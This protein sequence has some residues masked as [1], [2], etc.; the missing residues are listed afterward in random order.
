M[1]FTTNPE[2]PRLGWG[3]DET[4]TEQNE[5]YLILS[6]EE[7]AKGFI[8]PVRMAYVHIGKPRPKYPLRDL[9]DAE[10]EH[11]EGQG[12]VKFEEYPESERPKLGKYWTQAQLDS[13]ENGCGTLTIM[14]REF[15][16]TYARNPQFYGS[17]YCVGCKKH[18]PVSEFVWD[19]TNERV[20]S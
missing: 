20:G 5:V 3:Q 15:A 16:E 11:H 13:I 8:R 17:T 7:R 4:P 14:A 9:T 19:K 6:E 2:D 18:L 1:P 12:Y 10:K